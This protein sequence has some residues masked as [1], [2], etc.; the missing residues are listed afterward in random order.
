M[1]P[2]DGIIKKIELEPDINKRS[3]MVKELGRK[4]DAMEALITKTELSKED[5]K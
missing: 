2:I 4:L 1:N 3:D 5:A